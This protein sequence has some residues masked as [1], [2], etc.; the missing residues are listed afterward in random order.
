MEELIKSL[1]NYYIIFIVLA[2][3]GIFAIIGYYVDKKYP[4][5]EKKEPTI[6][7]EAVKAKSGEGLNTTVSKISGNAPV[8]QLDMSNSATNSKPANQ[9]QEN[10]V[11]NNPNVM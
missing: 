7:M 4:K 9:I 2:L 10:D 8:E 3:L 11:F 5:E 6:D 1:S